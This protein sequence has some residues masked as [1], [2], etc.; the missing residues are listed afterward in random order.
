MNSHRDIQS[1]SKNLLEIGLD[2]D[3]IE[4]EPVNKHQSSIAR[5]RQK[6][7]E[8]EIVSLIE[9]QEAESKK[10]AERKRRTQILEEASKMSIKE[11]KRREEAIHAQNVKLRQ[12]EEENKV[13]FFNFINLYF[14]LKVWFTSG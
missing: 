14:L 11:M 2:I 5:I 3:E 8:R 7:N 10:L 13:C 4:L 12:L 9:A 1:S 6:W